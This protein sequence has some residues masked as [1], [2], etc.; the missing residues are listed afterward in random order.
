M[1]PEPPPISPCLIIIICHFRHAA[2]IDYAIIFS[3]S[4]LIAAMPDCHY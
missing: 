2:T 4:C 1:P 3:P